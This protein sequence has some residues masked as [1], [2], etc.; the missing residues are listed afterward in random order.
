MVTITLRCPFCASDQL[1]K[2][3]ITPNGKRR[4]RCQGVVDSIESIRVPTPTRRQRG[5]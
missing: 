4:Y 2:Y 1:I 5:R 3:G